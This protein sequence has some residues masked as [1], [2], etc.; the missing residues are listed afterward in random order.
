MQ[1]FLDKLAEVKPYIDVLGLNDTEKAIKNEVNTAFQKVID[2]INP[3]ASDETISKVINLCVFFFS[4][5]GLK[6]N[7]NQSVKDI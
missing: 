7:I 5:D 2:F 4:S 6:D 1:V 3:H